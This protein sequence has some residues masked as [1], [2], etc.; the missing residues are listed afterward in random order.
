[1]GNE[2]KRLFFNTQKSITHLKFKRANLSISSVALYL[3]TKE[4]AQPFN[5]SSANNIDI[6][7][8]I[9]NSLKQIL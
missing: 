8:F 6:V 3:L 1:V 4:A 5:I 2:K 9:P 7:F